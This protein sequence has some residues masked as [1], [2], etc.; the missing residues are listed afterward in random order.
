VIQEADA[1]VNVNVLR[2]GRL[3]AVGVFARRIRVQAHGFRGQSIELTAVY[4]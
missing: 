2:L 3:E 1:A 4:G